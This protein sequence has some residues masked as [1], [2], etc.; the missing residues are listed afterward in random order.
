M[1]PFL[2]AIRAGTILI[3]DGAM[4]TQLEERGIHPGPEW[5]VK[6]PE[7]VKE[8][9]KAYADAGATILIANTF[10][11]NRI[12]LERAGDVDN[13]REYNLAG[14]KI[15]REAANGRAY[16]AGDISSTGQMLEPYGDYTE[17]QF[18]AVFT[19]QAKVLAEAG[20]DIFMVETMSDLREAVI[21]V[22]ACKA[23]SGI[24]VV[25]SMSFDPGAGG[26]KTMMGNDPETCALAL[27]E[28]GAD[29]IGTNCGGLIPERVADLIAS[30]RSVTD[31]PLVA[32]PNAG[33]PELID[34]KA[35]FSLPPD[36]FAQGVLKCI[37]SGAR[38]VGGCC[39]TNPA[40]IAA[41]RR[42]VDGFID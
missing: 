21:A 39:G 20:A 17:E 32:Q 33:L 42:A 26:P 24:P 38:I 11:A 10:S 40:H 1:T 12:S 3:F 37:E 8:V 22:R 4:G 34:G 16:V 28:A 29:V 27:D 9:H 23:V 18:M 25:A 19:E 13:L 2:E 30:M 41:L 15:C 36:A 14:V 7:I 35:V 31:K 6:S 5:N